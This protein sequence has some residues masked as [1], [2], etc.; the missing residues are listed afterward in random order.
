VKNS[1]HSSIRNPQGNSVF[2]LAEHLGVS[3][4]DARTRCTF[5]GVLTFRG[6]PLGFL[7]NA[8]PLSLT[9]ETH[10]RIVFRSGSASVVYNPKRVRNTL[11]VA[12]TESLFLKNA[13]KTNPRCSP[14]HLIV[15]TDN[16]TIRPNRCHLPRR[17][18]PNNPLPVTLRNV[19]VHSTAPCI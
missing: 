7:C 13:S 10:R 12:V 2:F 11:Y 17:P 1:S 8:D 3:S 5:S 4:I 15:S 14:D 9:S 18:T 16:L 19:T 6:R